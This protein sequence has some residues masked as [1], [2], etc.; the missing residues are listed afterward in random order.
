MMKFP[1]YG[2]IKSMFQ[3]PPTSIPMSLLSLNPTSEAVTTVWLS[4][5]QGGS[6]VRPEKNQWI[7]S[8]L[9]ST[10]EVKFGHVYA[11]M[12]N[13]SISEKISMDHDDFFL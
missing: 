2:K 1:V 10:L 8:S 11:S 12:S 4:L 9:E 3:S 7:V 5:V 13:P 6:L